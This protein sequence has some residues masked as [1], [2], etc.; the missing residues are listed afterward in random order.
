LLAVKFLR[1]ESMYLIIIMIISF[2]SPIITNRLF[3]EFNLI[4]KNYINQLVPYSGG[5]II[6]ISTV[7]SFAVI[8]F[9]GRISNIKM[10]FFI[11][12][13]SLAFTVGFFDDLFGNVEI[14]DIRSNLIALL[15]R[16]VS[17]GV[18]KGIFFIILSCYLY[19]FFNEEL[20]ILKGIMTSLFTNLFNLLDLR[21]GRCIK[22][23]FIF[24]LLLNFAYLR[25]T[26][27]LFIIFSLVLAI[28]YFWD[29][30]GYSMLGESG[31]NLVGF[32][33][34]LTVSEALGTNLI[35]IITVIIILVAVQFILDKYTFTQFIESKPL[36]NYIDRFLTERQGRESAESRVD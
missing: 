36:F 15:N 35:G 19:Y 3:R 20:W 2:I 11:L 22:F 7:L 18:I 34:G 8:E 30:Y 27:E 14:R 5:A 13:I 26:K 4:K 28:Y 33:T 25:W 23:Y 16:T 29:A 24:W 32:I 31:S 12:I 9:Y 17:M 6:F 21:P 1:G 10:I